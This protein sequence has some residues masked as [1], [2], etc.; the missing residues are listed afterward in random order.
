MDIKHYNQNPKRHAEFIK[1][2]NLLKAKVGS[3]GLNDQ[4]IVRAQALLENHSEEFAPLAEM[5]LF[6]MNQGIDAAAQATSDDNMEEVIADI[7]LPCMQLKSNGAMFHYPLVTRIAGRFIQFM[8]VIE[9]VDAEML[10]IAKAFY[11][12]IKVVVSGKIKGDG[13]AQ[14]EA[15]IEELNNACMRYFDKRKV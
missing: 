5:Y 7:L 2:P 13:G 14:G 4:V 12:T 15:L 3:G 6:Q 9:D 8:E 1:P 10:S 11:T